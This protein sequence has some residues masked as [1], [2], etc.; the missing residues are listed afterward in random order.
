MSRLKTSSLHVGTYADIP[1]KV[2]WTFGFTVML[3]GYLGISNGLSIPQ[4]VV[5]GAFVLVLFIC[6]VLHEYGHALAA[7]RYGIRTEDIILSPIGGIARL[8][9]LPDKPWQ[10][11]VI[12]IAGPAVNIVVA[13]I[14]SIV[15]FVILDQ[16]LL[17]TVLQDELMTPVDFTRSVIGVNV[18]LFAFN[19][20]PAFPMDGGRILRA[21]LSIP[22]GRARGTQYASWI[23]KILAVGFIAI[24]IYNNQVTL[25]LVGVFIYTM[26][27]MENKQVQLRYTLEGAQA[28]EIMRTDW[29]RVYE[30]DEMSTVIDNYNRGLQQS[31]IVYDL[32]DTIAGTIPDVVVR[33]AIKQDHG[34]MPVSH[35]MLQSIGY[36][37]PSTALTDIY[38]AFTADKYSM[39][40][41]RD[42]ISDVEVGL[43][44]PQTFYA[45][46]KRKRY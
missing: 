21:L 16:P 6:V 10:E 30:T 37:E 38:H 15:L 2:H 13:A 36:A 26:A 14:L 11:I 4:T 31:Y 5:L 24:A 44:D 7:R 8:H 1:V 34:G 3:V 40:V 22:W 43:I 29:L 45:Y 23:G 46:L 35:Y 19:L 39:I 25:G 17:P 41:V 27:G 33:E 18:A 12:A 42:R 28:H 9:H 20:V 32:G